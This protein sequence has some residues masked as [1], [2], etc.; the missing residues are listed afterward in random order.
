MFRRD[1]HPC[2]AVVT[3]LSCEQLQAVMKLSTARV[4][5]ALE[6]ADGFYVAYHTT[7][8]FGGLSLYFHRRV[9]ETRHVPASPQ[10]LVREAHG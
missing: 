9:L 2:I 10:H 6:R 4:R 1:V 7:E 5:E 8:T 3:A